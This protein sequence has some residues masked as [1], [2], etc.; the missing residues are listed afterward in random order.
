M[1]GEAEILRKAVELEREGVKYYA[2]LAGEAK[3]QYAR[4]FFERMVQEEQ[5]HIQILEDAIGCLKSGSPVNEPSE[6]E[7]PL[8]FPHDVKVIDASYTQALEAALKMEEESLKYYIEAS[9]KTSDE[10]LKKIYDY[11][12]DFESKHVSMLEKELEFM[13]TAGQSQI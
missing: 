11:L 6:Y 3:N 8:S 2:R 1:T 12:V 13:D 5:D 10:S 9:E 4:I 7:H